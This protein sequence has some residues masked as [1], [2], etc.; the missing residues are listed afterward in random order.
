MKNSSEKGG[1][2]LP[3]GVYRA[4]KK[5]GTEYYRSS[6]TYK[7][8]HISLGSY[9]TAKEAHN[10]YLQG[11]ALLESRLGPEDYLSQGKK[12]KGPLPFDKWVILVNFRDSGLYFKT[13]IVLGQRIFTYHLTPTE[14]LTFDFEDLFYYSQ[15]TIMRRGGHLFV[16]DYGSQISV[17]TRHGIKPYA[18]E[19]VDYRFVNGDPLDFRRE[20]LEILNVYH[21]VRAVEKGYLAR[22]HVNGYLQIGTY[23]SVLEAAIAYNKAADIL[24]KNGVDKE[25]LQNFIDISPRVYADIYASLPVSER[26]EQTFGPL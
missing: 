12:T 20:N 18:V 4:V 1:A 16:A 11:K 19:G 17:F 21:G 14:V 7:G 24:Q 23:P 10:A 22:I 6:L 5:D 13:P 8:K 25:Y 26:I 9:A 15:H 2:P 3:E